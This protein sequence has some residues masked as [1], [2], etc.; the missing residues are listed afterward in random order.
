MRIAFAL[1]GLAGFNDHGA[2]F[3]AA[4]TKWGLEPELVSATS[5]QIFVLA[6]WLAGRDPRTHLMPPSRMPAPLAQL[7][8]AI[9]GYPGVFRPAYGEALAR[10]TLVPNL[11]QGPINAF[12]DLFLP[13]QQ[14][15]P[16]RTDAD[17]KTS[18]R[19]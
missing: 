15:V 9:V 17:F 13:A 18:P 3:L 2:G 11:Q 5:G 19:R 10:L 12:A 7:Q 1:A 16:E 8:T 6:D 14:Y 4:A